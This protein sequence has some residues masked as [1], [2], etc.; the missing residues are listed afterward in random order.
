MKAIGICGSPR[1]GN[2]E[3]Y[4]REVLKTL[5]DRKHETVYLPLKL[6]NIAPCEGCYKCV[7]E[8]K[9]VIKDDFQAVFNHMVEADCIIM[10]SPVYNGSITPKLKAL[11]DRAGFSARWMKNAM[12]TTPV[13]YTH[14]TLPTKRIV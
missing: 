7:K 6:L 2:T 1:E 9:C 3:I 13:S 11:M 5:D 12:Q 4:I 10:G 8:G 14:L